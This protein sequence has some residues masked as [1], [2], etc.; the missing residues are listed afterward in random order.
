MRITDIQIDKITPE[1]IDRV[2]YEGMTDDGAFADA[3][4]VLGSR[5]AEVFRVPKAVELYKAGR[6]GK[7][8]LSGGGKRI[9]NDT[10]T[11][12][13]EVMAQAAVNM[14]VPED[15]LLL[16]TQSG[17]TIENILCA[18]L[19][20]QRSL[21]LNRINDVILTT[22]S[23]HMRRSLEITKYLFPKHIRIHPAPANDQTTRRDN[24]MN[25]QEGKERTHDEVRN[26]LT[27]VKNGVFP[28]F[29]I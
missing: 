26:I 1:I 20:L 13:A 9:I 22:A 4:I 11:T 2:L 18:L 21:W 8:V 6:A 14:G 15:A 27:C 12:E 16:D 23:C 10:E 17:N 5:R 24:W 29:E 28:D 3:I 25:S 7:I 19:L